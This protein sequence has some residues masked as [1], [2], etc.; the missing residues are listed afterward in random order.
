MAGP[1][2]GARADSKGMIDESVRTTVSTSEW[3]RARCAERLL[4]LPEG[5][6]GVEV[7]GPDGRPAQ[8]AGRAALT[9]DAAGTAPAH[10]RGGVLLV[11][12]HPPEPPGSLPPVFPIAGQTRRRLAGPRFPY[13]RG[14]AQLLEG[15]LRS[16][17]PKCSSHGGSRQPGSPGMGRP[18]R[19]APVD[20]CS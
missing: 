20:P 5:H 17:T 18:T 13:A 7:L 4:G 10:D 19:H 16:R 8:G 6:P 3:V 15:G 11:R 2:T 12:G 1:P 14:G 9:D